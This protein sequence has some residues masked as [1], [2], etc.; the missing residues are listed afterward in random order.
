MNRAVLSLSLT[1]MV[2]LASGCADV[3]VSLYNPTAI[4]AVKHWHVDFTYEAGRYE[5]VIRTEGGQEQ[6]VVREG[7]PPVDL[8]LR[9]D[10]FF[11]VRDRHGLQTV[12]DKG[13][14]EGLVRIHPLHDDYGGFK[15]LD[16]TLLD[17]ADEILARI[18]IENGARS[19]SFRD[20]DEFAEYCADAVG[21]VI[22]GKRR[23]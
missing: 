8:Q 2:A 12:K 11:R 17:K 9:D 15:S 23:K 10:I 7:H 16:V 3:R 20:N 4:D 1:A 14:A 18:R 21:D 5:E 13:E 19:A 22:T 6:K